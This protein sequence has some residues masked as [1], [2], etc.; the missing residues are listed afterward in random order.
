M[1]GAMP[2]VQTGDAVIDI[3]ALNTRFGDA[4]VH[5]D[6][7]LSVRRGEIFSLVGASGCGKSTLLRETLV[8]Q[9]P[10]SGSIRVFGHEVVGLSDEDA[11][12]LIEA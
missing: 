8:L 10:V 12:P 2:P 3:R 7:N 4:V 1:S 5:E 11:L 6:V 9:R